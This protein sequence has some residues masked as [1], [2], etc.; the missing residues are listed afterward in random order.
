[1]KKSSLLK[2]QILFFIG[3]AISIIMSSCNC[4]TCDGI[5]KADMFV[6]NVVSPSHNADG[7]GTVT[8]DVGETINFVTDIA[9]DRPDV[10]EDC[11]V[12]SSVVSLLGSVVKLFVDGSIAGQADTTYSTPSLGEGLV[13][14]QPTGL[15]FNVPG[16]YEF[17]QYS[18]YTNQVPESNESNN[19]AV[20]FDLLNWIIELIGKQ[21]EPEMHYRVI[22]KDPNPENFAMQMRYKQ[23]IEENRFV[24]FQ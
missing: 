17:T 10:K 1:M 14:S 4:D 7:T 2:F 5:Q 21:G 12:A 20:V 22:V 3:I 18:D 13:H 6:S 11:D 9:N 24:T 16:E 15:T 19:W 8:I 23:L